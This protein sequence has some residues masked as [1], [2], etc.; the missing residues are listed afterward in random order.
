MTVS[1]IAVGTKVRTKVLCRDGKTRTI[2]GIKYYHDGEHVVN[3]EDGGSVFLHNGCGNRNPKHRQCNEDIMKII[4][5]KPV[6]EIASK[7]QYSKGVWHFRKEILT[8][9]LSIV[10]S[11]CNIG[12]VVTRILI[13]VQKI[14]LRICVG[15]GI[16]T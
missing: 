5:E 12:C 16:L 3:F 9:L 1:W 14:V 2:G 6:Q 7:K 11:K 13:L 8:F 4:I 10:M 15:N